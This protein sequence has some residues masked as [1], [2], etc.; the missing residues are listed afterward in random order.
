MYPSFDSEKSGQQHWGGAQLQPISTAP[1]PAYNP[2][3]AA[4]QPVIITQ[5]SKYIFILKSNLSLLT[6]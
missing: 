4:T 6:F 3:S 1:P 5:P 2:Y